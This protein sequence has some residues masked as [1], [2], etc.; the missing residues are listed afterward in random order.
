MNAMYN[1]TNCSLSLVLLGA[2]L[3]GCMQSTPVTGV[4]N[5]AI[6]ET[7]LNSTDETFPKAED[8]VAVT[9][10][11]ESSAAIDSMALIQTNVISAIARNLDIILSDFSEFGDEQKYISAHPEE[12]AAIV[13][14]GDDALPYLDSVANGFSP[15][16]SSVENYR[17]VIAMAAKY[18]IK[19]ELYDLAYQSP[20][21]KFEIKLTPE[22]FYTRWDPFGGIEYNVRITDLETGASLTPP[23]TQ[24]VV[25][26]PTVEWSPDSKYAAVSRSHRHDFTDLFVFDIGNAARINLSDRATLEALFGRELVIY[27]SEAGIYYD[28]LHCYLDGWGEGSVAVSVF[29]RSANGGEVFFD[30]FAYD[31]VTG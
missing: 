19:P 4:D 25:S 14:L 12:F 26:C 20:D 27:D 28:R 18:A 29:L 22:T 24:T 3:T 13:A 15:Y 21:G 23:D 8:T 11:S 16:D 30:R 6:T 17:R 2:V 7:V 31:L 10:T 1:K 9:E 5:T